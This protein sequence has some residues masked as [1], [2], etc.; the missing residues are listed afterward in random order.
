MDVIFE[1]CAGLASRVHKKTVVASR[2][3]P[4]DRGGLDRARQTFGT[5]TGEL[6]K[7]LDWLQE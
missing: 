5:T 3:R 1:R 7:L 4:G 2:I 6:L